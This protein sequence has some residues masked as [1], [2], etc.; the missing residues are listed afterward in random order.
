VEGEQ[1]HPS[2]RGETLL[3]TNYHVLSY[4]HPLAIPPEKALAR[5]EALN[6][7][8]TYRLAEEI[9]WADRDLDA[10]LVRFR[11]KPP[12]RVA[13]IPLA[14]DWPRRAKN[15]PPPLPRVYVIGHPLG[16]PMAISLHDNELL[17]SDGN[18]LHY[19]AP[20]EPGSSGSPV[21]NEDWELVGLHH[22]GDWNVKSL[23]GDDTTYDANEA[24]WIGAISARCAAAQVTPAAPPRPRSLRRSTRAGR[25]SRPR[26]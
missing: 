11:S 22:F 16:G 6:K 5:F 1:F 20:T 10:S 13:G 14:G 15:Q 7:T 3:L 26:R 8:K 2:L 19:R 17:A 25:A 4:D 9:V 23:F 21:F 24:Y 18:R 12:A